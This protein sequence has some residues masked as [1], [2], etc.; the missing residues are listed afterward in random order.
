MF[1]GGVSVFFCGCL[2][3]LVAVCC[4]CDLLC[5]FFSTFPSGDLM[6]LGGVPVV[7]CVLKLLL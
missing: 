5:S 4:Y 2:C 7:L 6:F 3:V 1:L